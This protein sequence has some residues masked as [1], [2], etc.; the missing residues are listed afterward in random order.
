MGGY[1]TD[2]FSFRTGAVRRRDLGY[3]I[4]ENDD[5]SSKEVEHTAVFTWNAAK[6]WGGDD[7][8]WTVI[9]ACVCKLPKEQLVAIGGSGQF[10]V[11]GKGE[12]TEGNIR[13]NEK[14]TGQRGPLRAV[15]DVCG[16]AYAVG[17][18]H[19][20]YRRDDS[21]QWTP[22]G[23]GT[24]KKGGFEAIHGFTENDMYAVGRKGEIWHYNGNIWSP[25]NSPTNLIL[26]GVCCAD[27][28]N[29]YCCGQSGILLRG[30]EDQWEIIAQDETEADFW[31]I[32]WFDGRI[33]LSTIMFLYT[34]HG[35]ALELVF[36]GEDLP[37][38]CYHLSSADGVLW[39][40]GSKD[41]MAFDG[42]SWT[43]I[44]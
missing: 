15:R 29:V 1:L 24:P 27:D 3:L 34:L 22:I 35:E 7:L 37:S 12:I 20:V 40:I 25:I 13:N 18:N 41:V 32:E 26:T 19:Q 10:L 36:F 17:L 14:A 4:A 38:S 5:L 43:R 16:R 9:S 11:F 44:D 33:Y 42:T 28:G 39:S 6:G 23:L 21:S 8:D 30:R 2:E 31:D